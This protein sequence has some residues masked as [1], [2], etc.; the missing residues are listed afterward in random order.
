M[1]PS[2]IILAGFHGPDN[3]KVGVADIICIFGFDYFYG[4]VLS[5][6]LARYLISA[7]HAALDQFASN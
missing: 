7:P 1:T 5:K 3:K 4:A 2:R 6:K